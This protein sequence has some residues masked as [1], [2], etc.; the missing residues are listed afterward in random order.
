M[1]AKYV[2]FG[3]KLALVCAVAM[4]GVAGTWVLAR[5]SIEEGKERAFKSAI[6]AV[7]GLD[8]SAPDPEALDPDAP[9]SDLVFEASVGG[10]KRYAAQGGDGGVG[11]GFSSVVI[12]AVGARVDE[13]GDLQII[14]TRVIS[15]AET[16]GL[17]T[18]VA[19]QETNL[20]LWSA[21]GNAL[22]GEVEEETDW[23]FLKRYRNK[24][25]GNL[26]MTSD[27]AEAS[28]KILKITGVT[29]TTT[30]ATRAVRHALEKIRT[31]IRK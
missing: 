2:E 19:E 20:T 1:K 27:P 31:Q 12:M 30:A 17:G 21:I 3:G 9:P 18:R 15:Q 10:E 25:L 8:A 16:P 28:E 22:G 7:L 26:V 5:E 4:V 23:Y 13:A 24:K 11:Q 29:V 6:R 14:E